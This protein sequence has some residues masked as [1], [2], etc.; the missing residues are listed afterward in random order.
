ME[1]LQNTSPAK[2]KANEEMLKKNNQAGNELT[3]TA[4]WRG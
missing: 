1:M 3:G 4:A 2:I